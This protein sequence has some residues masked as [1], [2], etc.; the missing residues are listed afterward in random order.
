MIGRAGRPQYDTTGVAIILTRSDKQQKYENV[1]DGTE[2][3]ESRLLEHLIEHV[4][5]EI[6][7]GTIVD[8]KSA[9][10]W[11]RSTFLYVRC[12]LNPPA[13]GLSSSKTSLEESIS[14]RCQNTLE[15]LERASLISCVNQKL[16]HTPE[17]HAASKF[18]LR[19]ETIKRLNGIL[20]RPSLRDIVFPHF[21]GG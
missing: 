2:I 19:F 3:L 12:Q 1:V 9:R 21:C 16:R 4:N 13:Y 10:A 6:G 15:E 8:L 11:L 17:G 18:Y 14:L 5:A 7:L 20:P